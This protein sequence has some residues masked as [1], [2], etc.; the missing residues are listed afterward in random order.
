MQSVSQLTNELNCNILMSSTSCIVHDAQTGTII[1]HST[2]LYYVDEMTQQSQA[3]L[4]RGSS[5]HHL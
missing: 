2:K 5:D 3:M 4:T 1:G